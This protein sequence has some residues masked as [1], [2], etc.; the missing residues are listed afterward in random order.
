MS[1]WLKASYACGVV[2]LVVATCIFLAWLVTR[3]TV[4]PRMGIATIY[5]GLA[6]VAIGVVCLVTHAVQSR[7][8]RAAT[9]RHSLWALLVL[10]SNF[11]AAAGFTYAAIFVATRYAVTVSNHAITPV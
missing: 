10:L 7:R 3:W 5:G 2:P 9:S 6:S 11:P 8:P 1:N 4:L